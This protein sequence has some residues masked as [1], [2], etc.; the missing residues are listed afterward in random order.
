MK[1]KIILLLF[2]LSCLCGCSIKYELTIDE[3][4]SF[5]EDLKLY[6]T[7]SFIRNN[8]DPNLTNSV[9]KIV[10][11]YRNTD[12]VLGIELVDIDEIEENDSDSIYYNIYKTYSDIDS[13]SSSLI[14]SNYFKSSSSKKDGN[15]YT[16]Y[17]SNLNY[18]KIKTLSQKYQYKFTLDK[19]YLYITLPFEVQEHNADLVD[20]NSYIWIFSE[21][22]SDRDI[23]LVFTNKKK[24]VKEEKNNIVENIIADTVETVTG[25]KVDGQTWLDKYKFALYSSIIV[26]SIIVCVIIIRRKIQKADK[27]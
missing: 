25:G 21:G 20:G 14:I 6:E 2:C 26:I 13:Y 27:L 8:V 19:M 3:D 1:K 5:Y 11:T 9:N 15:E 24:E 18:D 4:L 10:A 7:K 22:A 12:D 23:K 16:I 17:L